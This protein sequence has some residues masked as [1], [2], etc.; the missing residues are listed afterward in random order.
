MTSLTVT[1]GPYNSLGPKYIRV[2]AKHFLSVEMRLYRPCDNVAVMLEKP[3]EDIVLL[4]RG[5]GRLCFGSLFPH[6]ELLCLSWRLWEATWR[7]AKMKFLHSPSGK[8]SLCSKVDCVKEF[9][10]GGVISLSLPGLWTMYNGTSQTWSQRVCFITALRNLLFFC[11]RFTTCQWISCR[12]RA[13]VTRFTL[14]GPLF[15]IVK[16]VMM[17]SGCFDR[18]VQCLCRAIPVKT[19]RGRWCSK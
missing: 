6:S 13:L 19:S 10:F 11:L 2:V 14:M 5:F 7:L 18:R 9:Y 4:A 15:G 3:C 17:I 1:A 12:R 16:W 8:R